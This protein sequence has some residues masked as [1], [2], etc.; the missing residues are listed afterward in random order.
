MSVT[1]SAALDQGSPDHRGTPE[2]LG[3]VATLVPAPGRRCVGVVYRV[4]DADADDVLAAL[5]V[6]NEGMSTE[7]YSAA[8]RKAS[9]ADRQEAASRFGQHSL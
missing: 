4:R 3:R 7:R 1:S 9:R 2:R 5:D 8:G 6:Q